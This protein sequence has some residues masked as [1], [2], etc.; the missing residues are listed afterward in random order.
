VS[1]WWFWQASS[2]PDSGPAEVPQ[3]SEKA[4]LKPGTCECDH[5]RCVHVGGTGRCTVGYP[6]DKEWPE[7]ALC[8]CQVFILDDDDDSDDDTPEAPPDDPDVAELERMLKN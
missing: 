5:M 1:K 6:P 2:Q 7:G 8:A 3:P 4:D